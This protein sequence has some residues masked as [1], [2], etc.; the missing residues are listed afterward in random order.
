MKINAK[1]LATFIGKVTINGSITD[2]LLKFGPEGLSISVKDLVNTGFSSGLLKT[3][4]GFIDYVQMEAPVRNIQKV[5]TFLKNVT[6]N[7][8]IS[9]EGNN[10][11]LRSDTNDAKFKLSEVQYLECNL[12]KFP[13]LESHDAGFE[14][15]TRVLNDA[16]KNA[17][18]TGSK[19]L[20]AE[21]KDGIFA[22]TAGEDEFDQI[23]AHVP[24]SYKDVER[25]LY[26]N[27]LLDF[28]SV[29][30]GKAMVTFA[31]DYPM[32][33]SLSTTDCIHKWLIAPMKEEV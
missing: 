29:I 11:I 4:A 31:K 25:T 2:A 21:V 6:G 22:I 7:V 8:D 5:L 16:K 1:T 30:D 3:S 18:N 17:S 24:V 13:T 33:I 27:I 14:I 19:S 26:T 10:F 28:I 23:V 12:E 20:Y 15:D 32:L 9:I